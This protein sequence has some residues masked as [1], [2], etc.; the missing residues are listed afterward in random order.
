MELPLVAARIAGSEFRDD[1]LR[2]LSLAQQRQ[3]V[4]TVERVDEGLGRDRADAAANMR[5]HAADGEKPAGDGNSKM[6]AIRIPC[7]DRPGHD[8]LPTA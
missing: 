4:Y 1:I 7:D 8:Y 6:A 5:N 2:G 3:P